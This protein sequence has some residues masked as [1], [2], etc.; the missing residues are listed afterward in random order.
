MNSDELSGVFHS[1]VKSVREQLR[2]GPPESGD[3]GLCLNPRIM[4]F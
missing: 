3:P 4:D 1:S 2:A